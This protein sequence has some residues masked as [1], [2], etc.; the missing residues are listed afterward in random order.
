MAGAVRRNRNGHEITYEGFCVNWWKEL[1]KKQADAPKP[2]V[3]NFSPRSKRV[4]LLAR[5]EAERLNHNF[6]GTEHLLLGLLSFSQATAVKVLT[7]CGISVDTIR[8]E[9]MKHGGAGPEG[10]TI[11]N[12][13]YTPRVK[14]VLALAVKESRALNHTR[15][16]TEHLL[17]GFL[18]E[19]DSLGA[20]ILRN[21]GLGLEKAREEILKELD[22]NR[23]TPPPD[24]GGGS[25]QT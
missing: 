7:R 3:P 10:K 24:D 16:G 14:K 21:L 15:V 8:V 6:V 12:V 17:L 20:R 22:A 2:A 13:A 5:K 9:V 18:R 23:Q 11:G 1:W 25:S 19:G 4:L